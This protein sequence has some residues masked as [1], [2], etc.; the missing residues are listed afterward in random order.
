MGN[1]S[2]GLLGRETIGSERRTRT[3][4]LGAAVRNF[5]DMA[6]PGMG[7]VWFARQLY[8]ATLGIAVNAVARQQGAATTNI[9]VANALEALGCWHAFRYI[10]RQDDRLRGREKLPRNVDRPGFARFGRPSFYVTQPMRMQ[11]VQAVRELGLVESTGERFNSYL[12]TEAGRQFLS[13]AFDDMGRPGNRAPLAAFADWVCGSDRNMDT[14]VIRQLLSPAEPLPL[15]ACE[16]LRDLLVRGS[17][18]GAQRRRNLL[19]WCEDLRQG[20]QRPAGRPRQLSDA[21]WHELQAGRLFFALQSAAL[22]ALDVVEAMLARSELYGM[23]L[24]RLDHPPVQRAL[25]ALRHAAV[26]YQAHGYQDRLATGAAVFALECVEAADARLIASL[27]ARDGRVLRLRDGQVVPGEAFLETAEIGK[28]SDNDQP[29][30]GVAEVPPGLSR[31]VG[32]FYLLN[33]DLNGALA[34][35][36]EQQMEKRHE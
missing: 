29:E 23:A 9:E 12:V 32:N 19:A 34:A 4:G 8:L 3:L 31:R 17:S 25:A 30:A 28:N 10:D 26:A 14:P 16:Q 27:V 11:T 21:H 7:G 22:A 35:R 2:W 6:V 36:L 13:A 1:M 33:L 18:E 24:D 15:S 20:R 5:N